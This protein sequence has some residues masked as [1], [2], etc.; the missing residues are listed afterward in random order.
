MKTAE[1]FIYDAILKN[2]KSRKDAMP[3]RFHESAARTISG[4]MG[5]DKPN[6]TALAMI[7]F[8]KMH[9]KAALEAASKKAKMVPDTNDYTGNT[10]SEYDVSYIINKNSILDAYPETNIK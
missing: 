4:Y 3:E 2:L 9:V 7:E 5:P 6:I 8:A 10:G 1:E